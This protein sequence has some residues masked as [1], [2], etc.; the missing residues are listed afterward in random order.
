MLC[1]ARKSGKYK[2]SRKKIK[3]LV[4]ICILV[5]LLVCQ[6]GNM[7]AL[8]PLIIRYSTISLVRPELEIS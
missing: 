3:L 2:I 4:N 7:T 6:L 5:Q 8:S 1:V